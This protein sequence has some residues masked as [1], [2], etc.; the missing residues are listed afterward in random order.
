MKKILVLISFVFITIGAFAQN[1]SGAKEKI[2]AYKVAYITEHLNL[3][4]SEAER[5]WPIYNKHQEIINNFKKQRRQIIR[6]L[7]ETSQNSSDLSNER[8]SELLNNYLDAEEKKNESQETSITQLRKIISDKKVIQLIKIE[9]DFNKR[10]L[11]KIRERKRN[12]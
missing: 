8:V 9:S 3:T 10:I 7:K 2:K 12:N 5:F 11:D 4:S 6:S 1:M